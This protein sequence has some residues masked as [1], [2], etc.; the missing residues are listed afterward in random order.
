MRGWAEVLVGRRGCCARVRGRSNR[1]AWGG[2]ELSTPR[3]SEGAHQRSVRRTLPA[4]TSRRTLR[5]IGVTMPRS[6]DSDEGARGGRA[7]EGRAPADFAE[8]EM[9]SRCAAARAWRK[10]QGVGSPDGQG[11]ARHLQAAARQRRIGL[12]LKVAPPRPSARLSRAH[13]L[14]A[15]HTPGPPAPHPLSRRA[16]PLR[17]HGPRA[18]RPSA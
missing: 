16:G 13:A 4:H 15:S 12:L 3:L 14:G 6:E 17:W 7:D 2:V 10:A 1:R 11:P 5:T 18:S 9:L 8:L